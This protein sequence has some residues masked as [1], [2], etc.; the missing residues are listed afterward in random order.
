MS[1]HAQ[2]HPVPAEGVVGMRGRLPVASITLTS[3]DG[4]DRDAKN[5]PRE[6][7][8]RLWS[9]RKKD[10]PRLVFVSGHCVDSVV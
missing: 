10:C 9:T 3:S 1:Q 2:L 5:D 4:F 8:K 7:R 6:D